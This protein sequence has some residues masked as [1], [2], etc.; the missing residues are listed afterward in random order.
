MVDCFGALC[1]GDGD[2]MISDMLALF[3]ES[4][5]VVITAQYSKIIHYKIIAAKAWENMYWSS[6]QIWLS[7]NE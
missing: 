6:Y 3:P 2:L 5:S 1:R 7:G 4:F